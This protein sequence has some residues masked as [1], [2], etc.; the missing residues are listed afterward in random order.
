M[1]IGIRTHPCEAGYV[2]T[3]SAPCTATPLLV[4]RLRST[5]HPVVRLAHVVRTRVKRRR[6]RVLRRLHGLLAADAQFRAFHEGATDVL[7]EYYH[8]EYE[9]LLGPF[10]SLMP[11]ADRRP[12]LEPMAASLA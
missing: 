12:V 4:R 2:G 3:D 9:R 7:P 8:R 10:A 1:R 5:T 11:R 6:L